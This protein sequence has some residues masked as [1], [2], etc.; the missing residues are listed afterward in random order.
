MQIDGCKC[1]SLEQSENRSI[2]GQQTIHAQTRFSIIMN[3]KQSI[4]LKPLSSI[5]QL[6]NGKDDTFNTL[7]SFQEM[8]K[9]YFSLIHTPFQ[10]II[11]FSFSKYIAFAMHLYIHYVQNSRY[12]NNK[13]FSP[14]Q[15]RVG[16][17]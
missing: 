13:A 10:I 3:K 9:E 5:N 16:K 6:Q 8:Y 14:K 7:P 12:N 2:L 15:V 4:F 1:V 11:C 17:S